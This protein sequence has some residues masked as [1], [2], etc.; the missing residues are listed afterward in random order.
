[1]FYEVC[2]CCGKP[3]DDWSFVSGK[4]FCLDCLDF[5]EDML[6]WVDVSF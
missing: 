4:W 2:S 1:M 6:N 5:A 3:C